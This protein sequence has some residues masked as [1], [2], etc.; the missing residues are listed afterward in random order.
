M[1]LNLVGYDQNILR[2]FSKGG[3]GDY[4]G[5]PFF[6]PFFFFFSKIKYSASAKPGA[7]SD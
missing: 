2:Q 4:L 5:L 6:F 7:R 3:G 1:Y